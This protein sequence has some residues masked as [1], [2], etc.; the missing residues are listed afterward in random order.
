MF[1]LVTRFLGFSNSVA[2]SQQIDPKLEV[3]NLERQI[4]DIEKE[5]EP[6]KVKSNKQFDLKKFGAKTGAIGGG[7]LGCIGSG[8]AYGFG[9]LGAVAG[10][11]TGGLAL[12]A[13][14][15]IGVVVAKCFWKSDDN[16][17][18]IRQ[19]EDIEKINK[20][21][22][23]LITNKLEM[24]RTAKNTDV[25]DFIFNYE[26]ELE[27]RY[28]EKKENPLESNNSN[29]T[30]QNTVIKPIKMEGVTYNRFRQIIQVR[31]EGKIE[32]RF[33]FRSIDIS[34]A[35]L[36]SQNLRNLLSA[37]LGKFNTERL[38]LRNN[39]H[40]SETITILKKY[41][42][43]R[44]DSFQQ[45]KALDL[46]GNNLCAQSLKDL[47]EIANYLGLEEFILSNN[48]KL[49]SCFDNK[50]EFL[51]Y[52]TELTSFLKQKFEVTDNKQESP[53]PLPLKEPENSKPEPKL[54]KL[55]TLRRLH[56]QNVGMHDNHAEAVR[57]LLN[58]LPCLEFLDLRNNKKLEFAEVNEQ[59]IT[60]GLGGHFSLKE[61]LTDHGFILDEILKE[62]NKVLSACEKEK[63][64]NMPWI[65]YILNLKIQGLKIP[66]LLSE[67]LS[68]AIING[69]ELDNIVK[70][71]KKQRK[72]LGIEAKSTSPITETE[73]FRVKTLQA[74]NFYEK[75]K[76]G[77]AKHLVDAKL[78]NEIKNK[79]A[80]PASEKTVRKDEKGNNQGDSEK[81]QTTRSY[82][83][84]KRV[85]KVEEPPVAQ[86][87]EVHSKQNEKN[88]QSHTDSA[89]K[90]T[91]KKAPKKAPKAAP[92]A[93][94]KTNPTAL[95]PKPILHHFSLK[96]DMQIAKENAV[97]NAKMDGKSVK[98]NPYGR[99]A[100]QM[101]RGGTRAK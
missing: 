45:L 40:T 56:L 5:F 10:V 32:E 72:K 11:A 100:T 36:T 22:P 33:R 46:S 73:F 24:L 97:L 34:N 28:I 17:L 42:V 19:R 44:K 85:K 18:W 62:R 31:S 54:F 74:R 70:D 66:A 4:R 43:E 87:K 41:I 88:T 49:G 83:T 80:T 30:P 47:A 25:I 15:G 50:G 90:A 8:I 101:Q 99:N 92:K 13:G 78:L 51:S 7:F 69:N 76:N 3:Q 23:K 64:K 79:K 86:T 59:V 38:V 53:R 48:P 65:I 14:A 94:P 58:D 55:T 52:T 68:K 63:P 57:S 71:I 6:N 20:L 81:N 26:H 16:K 21:L 77:E 89:T 12:V 82:L 60:K 35:D 91:P 9:G 37:G 2:T 67:F 61:I 39:K 93:T 96:S 95:S 84:R 1:G 27:E 98:S 75:V 29:R